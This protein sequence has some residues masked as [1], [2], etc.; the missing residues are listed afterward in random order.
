VLLLLKIR[1]L[2]GLAESAYRT[3]VVVLEVDSSACS[4]SCKDEVVVK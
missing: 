2:P 1:Q 3:T 4:V